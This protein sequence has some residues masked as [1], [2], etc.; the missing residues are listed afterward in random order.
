MQTALRIRSI[1]IRIGENYA[2]LDE[3]L[4]LKKLIKISRKVPGGFE[5][6]ICGSQV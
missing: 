1:V 2:I 5:L 6:V 3:K 4:K